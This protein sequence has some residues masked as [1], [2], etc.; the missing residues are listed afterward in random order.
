MAAGPWLARS[1]LATSLTSLLNAGS[2]VTS[3]VPSVV[4]L[5]S[6]PCCETD[7]A[8]GDVVAAP[9][10]IATAT[11]SAAAAAAAT[12]SVSTSESLLYEQTALKY[13]H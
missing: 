3:S 4:T 11:G 5:S 7:D 2:F 10:F 6:S 8:R 12:A 9:S 13:Q 1:N